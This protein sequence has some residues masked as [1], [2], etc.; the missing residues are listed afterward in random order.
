MKGQ[1]CLSSGSVSVDPEIPLYLLTVHLSEVMQFVSHQ[2]QLVGH[3]FLDNREEKDTL[4]VLNS[5]P[6]ILIF[7]F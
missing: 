5:L 6:I 3:I 2:I 7:L 1:V 4:I